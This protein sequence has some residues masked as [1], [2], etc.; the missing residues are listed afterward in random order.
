M[1]MDIYR[2]PS[3]PLPDSAAVVFVMVFLVVYLLLLAFC[4]VAY[5][6][7]SLG[8]YTIAKRRGIH[9]P[10]LAWVPYGN[11]WILGSISDQY[12]YVAKGQVR[13]RRKV[14]L[15]LSIGS[16]VLLIPISIVCGILTARSVFSFDPSDMR[17]SF[18]AF[19]VISWLAMTGLLIAVLVIQYMAF[20]DLYMSCDPNTAVYFLVLSIFFSIT[21]PFFVFCSRKKDLGMPPRQAPVMPTWQAGANGQQPTWRPNGTQAPNIPPVPQSIEEENPP[22]DM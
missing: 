8:M 13:S 19:V 4:I 2:Y 6:F 10:W 14:L 11:L 5:V 12:R 17:M 3:T 18:V 16:S 22:K 7:E 15:G 9:K 20:Y 21:L 1:A